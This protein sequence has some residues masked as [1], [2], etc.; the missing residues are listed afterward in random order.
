[1]F[2]MPAWFMSHPLQYPFASSHHTNYGTGTVVVAQDYLTLHSR[3]TIHDQFLSVT[4]TYS[5]HVQEGP[6]WVL[7]GITCSE[8]R[9]E[10]KYPVAQ[11]TWGLEVI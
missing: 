5:I 2:N 9:T 6:P 1:M 11:Y 3:V 4:P 10:S 7:I 8:K